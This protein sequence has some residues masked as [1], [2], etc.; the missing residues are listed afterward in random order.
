MGRWI[1][2]KGSIVAGLLVLLLISLFIAGN[3]QGL[4][5]Q[6]YD[7]VG[8]P[9][10]VVAAEDAAS[11]ALPWPT[12]WDALLYAL[13]AIGLIGG[14]NRYQ[15]QARLNRALQAEVAERRRVEAA[16]RASEAQFRAL[17]EQST[18]GIGIARD[19][20]MLRANQAF[21]DMFSYRQS[22]EIAGQR[23]L[24]HLVPRE[25]STEIRRMLRQQL[26]ETVDA[27]VEHMGLR[28]DGTTFPMVCDIVRAN[29][30]DDA[31]TLI[32]FFTDLTMLKHAEEERDLFFTLSRNLLCIVGYD[33]YFKWLNPAWETT[34]GLSVEE[35]MANFY[36]NIV[37]PDDHEATRQALYA[38]AANRSVVGFEN[39]YRCKDGSYRWLSWS[40]TVMP[41]R[42]IVFGVAQ[43]V[44]DR[45]RTEQEQQRLY[46]VAEGLRE[47]IA[48]INSRQSLTNVLQ[49]VIAQAMRLLDAEAGV[50]YRLAP[51]ADDEPVRLR[52]EAAHGLDPHYLG[53]TIEHAERTICYEAIR[54][55]APVALDDA[56]KVMDQLLAEGVLGRHYQPML[57]DLRRR[58]RAMLTVPLLIKDEI[59]GT[60]TLYDTRVRSFNEEEIKLFV[61]FARQS[62]L[63][64][65]NGQ[66]RQQ[67]QQTAIREERSR[68][69]RE[70]HDSVTQSLYSLALLAE[71][72]RLAA[73]DERR[74]QVAA[75]FA[76]LGAI[77]QQSLREMRLLIHQLRVPEI[78]REGLIRTLQRRL[79]AVE[80]RLGIDARLRVDGELKL[81]EVAEEQLYWIIQEALN[82]A[83]KHA[84]AAAVIV[85]LRAVSPSACAHADLRLEAEVHDN[86]SGFNLA[87]QAAGFGIESMR[88]RAEQLGATLTIH[89]APGA[90]SR[91]RIEG[92]I[93]RDPA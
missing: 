29:L 54:Q 5:L 52:V 12:R 71:G 61:S 51:S 20:A 66:L 19:G 24:D 41:E 18:V 74:D 34:L 43:D 44:T 85:S 57:A 7:S 11:I 48:V 58:M 84:G 13:I 8:L 1:S 37:H 60:I 47:V 65:E 22:D 6:L 64:I 67:V 14:L 55:R 2:V 35:L 23:M 26:G 92:C 70:L 39:R 63:A 87:T 15:A 9:G 62:A 93:R 17:F 10:A 89:T 77:A 79:D 33:G 31:E 72:W 76:R 86:G 59:Y 25:R 49:F 38:G 80:S 50:I 4:A 90:G 45:K 3:V 56:A 82:N 73:N 88:E 42:K 83:L 28:R 69:A 91:V 81:P 75:Q 32:G 40:Y 78:H 30:G 68:L 21:L 36:I 53:V 27:H 46:Q 16:L